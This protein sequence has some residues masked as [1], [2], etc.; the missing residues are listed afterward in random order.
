MSTDT[1]FSGK[2]KKMEN[3]GYTQG[4]VIICT[5]ARFDFATFVI[6]RFLAD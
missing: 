2:Q 6:L 4:L 1:Y 3:T 5:S